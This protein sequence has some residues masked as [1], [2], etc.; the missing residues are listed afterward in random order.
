MSIF[1]DADRE[2]FAKEL[3]SF[4]PDRVFDAHT[5]VWRR[6]F[7]NWV[8]EIEIDIDIDGYCEVM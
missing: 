7:I 6:D 1:E 3:D 5:H 2:F 4:V 8:P